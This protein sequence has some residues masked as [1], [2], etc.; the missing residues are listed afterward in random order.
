M[1]RWDLVLEGGYLCDPA[2]SLEGYYDLAIRKGR[3]AK[4]APQI[5][6][7]GTKEV[8]H[9]KGKVIV[10]GLIDSHIHFS[11]HSTEGLRMVAKT[12]VVT[13]IDFSGD[14]SQ[15]EK[16]VEADLSC[17]LNIGFLKPAIPEQTLSSFDPSS[18][19]L[20]AFLDSAKREGALGIKILGGHYP[21]TPG[22]VKNLIELAAKEGVF[23]ASHVGTTLHGSNIEGLRE[24]IELAGDNPLYLAHLQSYTRGQTGK[25][26]LWEALEAI[27]LVAGAR[28]IRSES[29]LSPYNGTSGK[30]IEGVP[31]SHVTRKCLAMGGFQETEEGIYNAILSGYAHVH[32]PSGGEI[33]KVTGGEAAAYWRERGTNTGLSFPVNSLSAAVAIALAKEKG[34]F[35]V[36]VLS[37]DGGSI[38]RNTLIESGLALVRMGALQLPEFIEK[39]AT[40]PAR[41]FKLENKGQLG[42][43]ADADITVLDLER[44]LACLSI[45]RGKL[46][47]VEGHVVGSGGY[48]LQG[49]EGGRV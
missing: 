6:T 30:C 16:A 32:V 17:G 18:G 28:N 43:G 26:P 45:A 34:S 29:Y 37:T 44:D 23:V 47:M 12:G 14:R 35:V 11:D 7:Q 19:E 15:L 3:I 46:V 36:E 27:K 39:T 5:H 25:D 22:A 20:A 48:L 21:L 33:I 1:E 41:I 8:I 24:T 31:K 40:N 49:K 2:N 38:P 42:V 10:P 4:V 13:A 9:L